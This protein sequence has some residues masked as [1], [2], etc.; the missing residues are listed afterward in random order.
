[1]ETMLQAAESE[2]IHSDRLDLLQVTS[3]FRITF[4]VWLREYAHTDS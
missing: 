3:P 4:R 1:M 2:V